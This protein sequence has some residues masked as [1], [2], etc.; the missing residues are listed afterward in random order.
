[1]AKKTAT[2]NT[3]SSKTKKVEPVVETGR[4]NPVVETLQL[5]KLL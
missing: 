1:M 4:R 3:K 5:K 2:K